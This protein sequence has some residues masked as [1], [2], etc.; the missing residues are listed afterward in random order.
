[1]ANKDNSGKEAI[2][3][4][5]NN[6]ITIPA[7][8]RNQE[9]PP[10]NEPEQKETANSP[11]TAGRPHSAEPTETFS[12]RLPVE[13]LD[14]LNAISQKENVS[15][16]ELVRQSVSRSIKKYEDENGTVIPQKFV[17]KSKRLIF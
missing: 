9:Q 8:T 17:K 16:A 14:K 15:L 13:D 12:V 7:P 3:N 4:L 5:L 6:K 1:M 2:K 11:K 10:V